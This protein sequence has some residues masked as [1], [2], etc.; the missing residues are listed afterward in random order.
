MFHLGPLDWKPKLIYPW[1]VR[2]KSLQS[3]L[4]LCDPVDYS[5]PGSSVH[6]LSIHGKH[7][8]VGCHALLQ[9]IF[10]TQGQTL[11]LLL[12]LHCRQI[13][14]YLNCPQES[15]IY[16]LTTSQI[17]LCN[18]QD[19][20]MKYSDALHTLSSLISTTA[21][22]EKSYHAHLTDKKTETQEG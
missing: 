3:C 22:Q 11:H 12:L 19:R 1:C 13:L 2:A 4:T 15:P 9:G 10:P 6:P 16:L 8:G 14:Y 7:T 18:M 21:S 17:M 5:P 20:S